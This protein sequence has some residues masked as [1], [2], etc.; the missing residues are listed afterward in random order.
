MNKWDELE[1]CIRN[2]CVVI[3][4]SGERGQKLATILKLKKYESVL[5]FDNDVQKQGSMICGCEVKKPQKMNKETVYVIAVDNC[6]VMAQMEE[7]LQN[8][9]VDKLNIYYFDIEIYQE[10][11]K[12]LDKAGIETEL[13]AIC[14]EKFGENF[15]IRKP[16]T[17]N[18]FINWEKTHGGDPRRTQLAD[19]VAVR[20]WV[21]SKIGDAY[22]NECYYVFKDET[23]IDFDMLPD[24]YVLK[25]NN[26]SGRNIIVEDSKA[27][28]REE[29]KQQLCR[30]RNNNFAYQSF[31]MHYKDIEPKIIC[32]KFMEGIAE[33]L[34]DYNIYCFH[35]EPKY[36]WCIKGSHRDGCQATFYDK[37]WNRCEF[38]YGYPID[39]VMAPRPE[40]L[41]EMLELSRILAADFQHVRV[42]WYVLKTGELKFG[43]MSFSTWGG[44]EKFT[45]EEYDRKF[46]QL[47]M[48]ER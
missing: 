40:K 21:S 32:E 20:D 48:D 22:L 10:Y 45:P 42:D 7:Q 25:L 1:E 19:K 46:G 2:K 38:S 15:N 36:I 28:N 16:K 11:K 43:E 44:L 26:A 41:E 17:Y 39:P 6:A 35:G 14:K 23:E 30:W 13:E 9:D 34:Y 31:E 5:F 24:K 37:D 8:M 27:I 3:F 33:S 4:G 29:I 12:T 47:I 18:E